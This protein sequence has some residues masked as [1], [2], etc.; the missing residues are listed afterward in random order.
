METKLFCIY[1]ECHGC[2]TDIVFVH[3]RF[4]NVDMSLVS[5]IY[6]YIYISLCDSRT[7]G[8]HNHT[9]VTEQLC[10]HESYG[11]AFSIEAIL[12]FEVFCI[13]YAR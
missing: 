13:K 4:T 12:L 8:V 11:I 5:S 2:L 7:C 6:I 3:R 9:F 10:S 1:A